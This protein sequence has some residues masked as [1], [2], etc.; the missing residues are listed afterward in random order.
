M[1]LQ[2]NQGQTGKQTG[3]N[4]TVGV[5][6]F[7]EALVT[8]LQP[9][10]LEQAYRGNIFFAAL[11]AAVAVTNLSATATGLILSNPAGSG[12][13]LW[14]LD[15]GVQQAV[16]AAAAIDS[17]VLAANVNPI[18]AATVHTTPLTVRAALLGSASTAVGLADSAAT[19]PAAPV[20]IRSLYAPSI[21]ATAT[22]SVPPYV[23]D[24]IAG[25][26]GLA[27]GTTISLSATTAIS[28]L[29]HISWLELPL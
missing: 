9:R 29:A 26:I 7:S 15:L 11:Q 19:L 12:K 3:Q 25:L 2:G 4:I 27:P 18:A 16:A 21:S 28:V 14:L 20:V 8:E 13:N 17:L 10:Y 6:E 22:T 1:L 24:E 23:K 5:G